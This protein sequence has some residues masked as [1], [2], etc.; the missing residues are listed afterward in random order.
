MLRRLRLTPVLL[1]LLLTSA[2]PGTTACS[3]STGPGQC[4]RV[5]T[6]SKACGDG[7]IALNKQC[8]KKRGCACNG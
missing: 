7:C 4:C 8:T 1:V 2:V 3:D 6:N 5:C